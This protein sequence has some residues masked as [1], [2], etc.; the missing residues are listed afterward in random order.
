MLIVNWNT[1]SLLH[2]LLASLGPALEGIDAEVVVVDNNSRDGSPE[3][4]EQEFP[5]VRLIRNAGNEGYARGNNRAQ[6]VAQGAYSLLLGSDTVIRPGSIRRLLE[7]LDNHRDVGAVSCRLLN[8]DGSPQGSCKRFPTLRDA[9]MTYLS[10]HFLTRRYNMLPFDFFRTQDV[11]QPSATC[12]MIR[13]EVIERVGLFDERYAILYNDVDLCHRIIS[14]G[15]RIVYLGDTEVV[16]HASQST[17]KANPPL[18]L[19]MYQ[20]ILRYYY[21]QF[22]NTALFVLLPILALRL[23]IVNRGR[24]VT[25]LFDLSSLDGPS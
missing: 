11:E 12:L 16:H 14:N 25:G 22:G 10:M 7:Y 17:R 2:A 6:S 13:R 15:W 21:D 20:D 3:M 9:A 23:A 8:P 18:R 5:F 19:A 1:S 24:S 4:V